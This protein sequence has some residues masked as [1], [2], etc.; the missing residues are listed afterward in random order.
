MLFQIQIVLREQYSV[1]SLRA[2]AACQT[3]EEDFFSK[4]LLLHI[5]P[6]KEYLTNHN[7]QINKLDV[8][9]SRG[10]HTSFSVSEIEFS[11]YNVNRF[12]VYL[13]EMY[14]IYEIRYLIQRFRQIL[15]Q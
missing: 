10:L 1:F 9:Y 14:Q 3:E 7:A 13:Q 2:G 11:K 6:D 5:F 12:Y 8:L 15:D 4:K